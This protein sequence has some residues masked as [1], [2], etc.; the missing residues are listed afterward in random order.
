MNSAVSNRT[1]GPRGLLWVAVATGSIL[2][3]P[4]IAMQ[5]TSEVNWDV[6]DFVV[7][8][9]LLFGTG[10]LLLMVS[11]RASRKQRLVISALVI[12]AFLLVWAELAV[13]VFTNLGS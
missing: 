10:S 8:G 12:A 9:L 7:M 11:R 5:F 13:G 6:A 3:I 1:S 2:L 4:A